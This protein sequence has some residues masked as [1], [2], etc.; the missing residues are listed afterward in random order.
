VKRSGDVVD[1]IAAG[2]RSFCRAWRT[3]NIADIEEG[4]PQQ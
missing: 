1:D 4:A 3:A 2:R